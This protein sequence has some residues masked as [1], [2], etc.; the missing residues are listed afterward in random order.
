MLTL[1]ES[2]SHDSYYAGLLKHIFFLAL[3]TVLWNVLIVY[4][5]KLRLREARI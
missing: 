2:R 1:I 5:K 4:F 3:K